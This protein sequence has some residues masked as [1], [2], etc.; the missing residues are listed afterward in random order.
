MPVD[1]PTHAATEVDEVPVERVE[2]VDQ[3]P[4]EAEGEPSAARRVLS[5]LSAGN[6]SAIYVFVLLVVIFSIWVPDTFLTTET[7]KSLLDQQ[8]LPALVALALVVPLAAGVFDLSIGAAVGLGAILIAWLIQ[9]KGVAL[10]PALA[11]SVVG[12]GLVGAVNGVLVT[13]MKIDSFIATLGTA[14]IIAA[15][16]FWISDQQILGLPSNLESIAATKLFGFTLPVY[17]VLVVTIVMWYVLERT[18]VGRRVYA[19][20][21]NV[22]AA[23]LSGVSTRTVV[24]VSFV[25]CSTLAGIVGVLITARLGTGDP[26]VGPPYLLPAFTAAFLGAT[27]FRGGRFNV[28]G[29]VLAVYVLAVGVKGLQL[30]GAPIWIPDLFNGTALILAVALAQ[31]QRGATGS[32][33]VNRLIARFKRQPD[34]EPTEV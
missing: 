23:R 6:I 27:Q 4:F 24:F 14:S 26:T 17:Y 30:G 34:P 18:P 8:A 25:I 11:I 19:T 15:M 9:I 32:S 33:H 1:E 5:A 22:D 29:T 10:V 31:Y 12:A 7:F 20:G 3:D 16:T 2:H 13:R 21:G 28:W